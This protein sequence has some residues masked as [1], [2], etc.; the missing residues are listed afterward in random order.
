MSKYRKMR[1]NYPVAYASF[2]S[3]LMSRSSAWN[4]DGWL[5]FDTLRLC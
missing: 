5:E 2:I 4:R 1:E 3:E